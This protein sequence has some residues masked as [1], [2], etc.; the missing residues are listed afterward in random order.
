MKE[1]YTEPDP[2]IDLRGDDVSRKLLILVREA[3]IKIE[4]SDIVF[5]S[6]LP[7]PLPEVYKADAFQDQLKS[8]NEYFEKIREG[9]IARNGRMRIIARFENGKAGIFLKGS[10]SSSHSFF[11][12]EGNDNVVSIY[13]KRYPER[14]LIIK[15][16]GAGA[17][18]TASGIFTDI[19]SIINN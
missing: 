13:S 11:Y 5:E 16:A 15:G 3:G 18:V 4:A 1:G 12:L 2:L 19:L 14:P 17:D 6:Y 9:T 10:G 8:Y 7:H